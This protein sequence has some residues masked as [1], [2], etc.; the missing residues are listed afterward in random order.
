MTVQDLITKETFTGNVKTKKDGWTTLAAKN[1]DTFTWHDS[2][3]RVV[4]LPDSPS[5]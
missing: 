3:K 1:R 5:K 4:V 2:N